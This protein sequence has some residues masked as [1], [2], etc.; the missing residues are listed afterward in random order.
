VLASVTRLRVRSAWFLPAFLWRTF[1]SQR[2]VERPSGFLGGRPLVDAHRT[3]WNLTVWQDEKS[4][5]SFRGSGAHA[6]VMKKLPDW[7]DEAAYGHGTATGDT[8]PTW[9]EAYEHRV[10][11]GKWSR[12]EHPS[13]TQ[14]AREFPGPRLNPLIGQDLKPSRSALSNLI[15][16]DYLIL[17]AAGGCLTCIAGSPN[18]TYVLRT[19]RSLI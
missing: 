18:N 16:V 1:Q 4:M 15:A 2:Q 6:R 5:K 11:V 9:P 10:A 19:S 14:E 13:A 3:Y 17:G 8:I 7:C 12:V